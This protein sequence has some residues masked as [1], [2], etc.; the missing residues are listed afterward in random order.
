MLG[1]SDSWY[2]NAY[3]D[4]SEEKQQKI[5]NVVDFFFFVLTE[6]SAD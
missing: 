6:W 5:N 3:I 4:V 2:F 1:L